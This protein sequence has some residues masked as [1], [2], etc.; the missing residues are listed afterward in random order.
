MIHM[1]Y[2]AA[3]SSRHFVSEKLLSELNGKP[4][5]LHGLE[6]AAAIEARRAGCDLTVVAR[7]AEILEAAQALGVR[8]VNSPQ[9]CQG[10]SCTIRTGL[11]S[12]NFLAPE[13]FLMFIRADQPW[14]TEA[15]IE[16]VMDAATPNCFAAV[17]CF[18]EQEGS[19]TLFSARLV[20]D[21]L[22]LKEDES[23]RRVLERYPGRASRVELCSAR[24]LCSVSQPAEPR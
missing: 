5:F 4:V 16:R 17:S 9:S 22:R 14:L 7:D 24:E 21:L 19:P 13:D 23:G 11:T 3:G 2:L 18:E 10:L 15:S 12:L 20:T 6:R 1:L 8:A